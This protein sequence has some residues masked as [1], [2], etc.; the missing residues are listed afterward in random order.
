MPVDVIVE[1]NDSIFRH[2]HGAIDDQDRN[3]V[4]EI[5]LLRRAAVHGRVNTVWGPAGIIAQDPDSQVSGVFKPDTSMA[6]IPP[7]FCE[8]FGRWGVVHVH[9]VTIGEDE[10][11]LAECILCAR[12]LADEELSGPDLAEFFARYCPFSNHPLLAVHNL[13]SLFPHIPGLTSN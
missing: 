11:H 3:R 10:L 5:D 13:E 9:V 8:E 7:R 6:E 4:R 1:V 12:L 2:N